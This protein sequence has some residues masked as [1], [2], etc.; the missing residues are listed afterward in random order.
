MNEK[1]LA[2]YGGPHSDATPVENSETDVSAYYYDLKAEDVAQGTH[3]L[4]RVG[5]QFETTATAGPTPATVD[6][7]DTLW[8][9][10]VGQVPTVSKTATGRYTATW[11]TTFTRTIPEGGA[12]GSTT[13]TLSLK[14]PIGLGFISTDP[15]DDIEVRVLTVSAN[16]VTFATY[17]PR[18]TLADVGDNSGNPFKVWANFR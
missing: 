6:N 11:S 1:S 9:S 3:V 15:A 16:E 5:L 2:G 18:G 17:S 14:R 13:E 7:H 12:G 10:G 4:S 8:G